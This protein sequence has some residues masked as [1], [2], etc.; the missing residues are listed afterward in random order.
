MR[1]VM[2]SSL[3]FRKFITGLSLPANEKRGKGFRILRKSE[4]SLQVVDFHERDA[5]RGVIAG[6]NGCVAARW[7][8]LDYSGLNRAGRTKPRCL[9][10]GLLAVV[11]IVIRRGGHATRVMNFQL[12]I[13]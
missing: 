4:P 8:R 5:R 1:S 3:F 13:G 11:P 9:N 2:E 6:E 12:R 10:F 7:Q